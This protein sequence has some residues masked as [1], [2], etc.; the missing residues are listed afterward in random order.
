[1]FIL[2]VFVELC[3]FFYFWEMEIVMKKMVCGKEKVIN[4][5]ELNLIVYVFY[6]FL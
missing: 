6:V 3:C 1:M 2:G 4:I 5:K